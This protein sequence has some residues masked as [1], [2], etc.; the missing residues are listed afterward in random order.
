MSGNASEAKILGRADLARSMGELYN[1]LDSLHS[2]VVDREATTGSVDT[3]RKECNKFYRALEEY[4]RQLLGSESKVDREL[5]V[6][7]S[8]INNKLQK[9]RESLGDL[10]NVMKA[11]D[12]SPTS[13]RPPAGFE[14]KHSAV[15]TA[16]EAII[17]E[18]QSIISEY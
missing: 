13:R 1:N 4:R 9:V 16:I 18:L 12:A 6:S 14:K 7:V 17:P 5:A 11:R 8:T 10:L 3:V 2:K 15:E